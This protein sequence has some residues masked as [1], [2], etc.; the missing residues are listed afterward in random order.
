MA[1][2]ELPVGANEVIGSGAARYER[3]GVY[4]ALDGV[5]LTRDPELGF[6]RDETAPRLFD[7]EAETVPDQD[8]MLPFDDVSDMA[9]FEK[10][11]KQLK[12]LSATDA[13]RAL[14]DFA[15]VRTTLDRLDRRR[16]VKEL[17]EQVRAEYKAAL[18]LQAEESEP[19]GLTWATA[20]RRSE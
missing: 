18:E 15:D 10:W 17:T 5:A 8:I 12:S 13:K 11:T 7:L 19:A 2:R 20:G 1:R 9:S 16:P 6:V 4:Y 3:D 14:A